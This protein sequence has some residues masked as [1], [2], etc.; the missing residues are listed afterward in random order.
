MTEPLNYASKCRTRPPSPSLS[1]FILVTAVIAILCFSLN[2][3][4]GEVTRGLNLHGEQQLFFFLLLVVLTASFAL[5]SACTAAVAIIF[6]YRSVLIYAS[7]IVSGIPLAFY[8]VALVCI[9]LGR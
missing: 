3:F 6:H 7:L 1:S 2:F 9:F 8:L 5:L 4:Y